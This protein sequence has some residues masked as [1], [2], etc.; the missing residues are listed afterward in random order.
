Q[1]MAAHDFE[2]LN[3]AVLTDDRVQTHGAGDARLTCQRWI[4]RLDTVN[5]ARCL[6]VAAYAKR[7]SQ[8]R[9][10]WRR[11]PAHTT[12][13]ATE[14]TAHGAAGDTARNAAA[15]ANGHV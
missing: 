6:N 5:D 2:L 13:N 1:G 11:R 3:S 12:D 4:N 7:A 9:F 15:H 14:H 8:L 10:R